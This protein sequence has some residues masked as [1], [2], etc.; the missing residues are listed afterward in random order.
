MIHTQALER[1]GA[2]KKRANE[3]CERK[4]K[5][6][7]RSGADVT[8]FL[9]EKSKK[10]LKIRKEELALKAKEGEAGTD[11]SKPGGYDRK[12]VQTTRSDANTSDS[13]FAATAATN[14]SYDGVIRKIRQQVM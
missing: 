13:F 14:T 1:V 4:P 2:T 9:R 8:E 3:D 10:E 7:C 12:H 5:S 6:Q 11:V